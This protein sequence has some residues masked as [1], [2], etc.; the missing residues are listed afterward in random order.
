MRTVFAAILPMQLALAGKLR[1]TMT[2]F[3]V[4]RS[5][6]TQCC[7]TVGFGQLIE[8]I[9]ADFFHLWSARAVHRR[10]QPLAPGWNI[11][12]WV[13]S[14]PQA[15]ARC[16]SLRTRVPRDARLSVLS[17]ADYDPFLPGGATRRSTVLA[18]FA[19][20][21]IHVELH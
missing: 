20:P 12:Y 18:L 4:T 1:V 21:T 2:T 7:G 5:S 10:V 17:I 15:Q 13:C 11:A 6:R 3:S 9:L 14:A 16:W 8:S 19:T